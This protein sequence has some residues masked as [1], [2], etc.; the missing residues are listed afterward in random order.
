[1]VEESALEDS[2]RGF[3]GGVVTAGV[4]FGRER[5]EEHR[6]RAPE[7]RREATGEGGAGREEVSELR[8]D[9]RPS[10]GDDLAGSV[11]AGE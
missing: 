2:V 5:V 6:E 8:E 1:M 4:E 11:G 3:A 9:L 10:S 7:A